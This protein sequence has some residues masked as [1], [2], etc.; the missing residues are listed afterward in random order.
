MYPL[1]A[2]LQVFL[3]KTFLIQSKYLTVIQAY[4]IKIDLLIQSGIGER[5]TKEI[6]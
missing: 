4:V 1:I 6:L 5:L 2:A 3:Y